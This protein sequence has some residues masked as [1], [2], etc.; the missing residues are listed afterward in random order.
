MNVLSLLPPGL[1]ALTFRVARGTSYNIS[2]SPQGSRSECL[3]CTGEGRS[4]TCRGSLLLPNPGSVSVNFKCDRPEDVI[5]VE[6][7][8]K[9]GKTLSSRDCVDICNVPSYVI[10]ASY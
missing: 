9:I 1:P 5:Q 3:V 7:Q 10:K 4:Q 6:I 8:Q 2:N